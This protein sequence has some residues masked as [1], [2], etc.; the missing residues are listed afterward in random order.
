MDAVA[1]FYCKPQMGG[2]LRANSRRSDSYGR[3][4]IPVINGSRVGSVAGGVAEAVKMAGGKAVKNFAR[5]NPKPEEKRKL[6]AGA[7]KFRERF[8]ESSSGIIAK[9]LDEDDNGKSIT[10]KK[11]K[12]TTKK[13]KHKRSKIRD[14]LG[15]E[16]F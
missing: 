10:S 16:S 5:E 14:F 8:M 15:D 2:A 4:S 3:F 7:N 13:R 6:H 1:E 9:A 12:K 11:R